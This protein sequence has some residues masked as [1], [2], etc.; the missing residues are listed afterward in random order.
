LSRENPRWGVPRIQAELALLGYAVADATVAKYRCRPRRP[1]S[2]SWR[3]FLNNHVQSLASIDFFVVPTVTF[4]LLYGFVV[5]RHDRRQVV[6]FNTT[7]HPTAEWVARQLTQAFPFDSAPR[8]LIRDNDGI[9]GDAVRRCLANLGIEDVPISPRSPWQNPFVERLIGSVRRDLLDHVIVLNERHLYRL[10]KSY[11]A[12]YHQSRTHLSLDRNA[13][14]PR[15]II[16][17]DNGPV[18]SIPEVGGLHHQYTR[19]A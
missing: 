7:A 3:S 16:L 9:Y 14:V 11:F 17:P 2:P 10:L 13:P 4:Q 8:Y 6:H 15:D 5:L 1:P 19:A 12:Y 18:R